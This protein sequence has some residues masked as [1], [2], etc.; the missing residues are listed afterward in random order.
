MV[1]MLAGE[2]AFPHVGKVVFGPGTAVTR[3]ASELGAVGAKAALIVTGRT[4]ANKTDLVDRIKTALGGACVG[5]FSDTFAHTP[6]ET[7]LHGAIVARESGADSLVALGGSTA[8]DTAKG[9]AL[10]LAEGPA[11]AEHEVRFEPPDRWIVPPLLNSKAPIIA[12]PTTLSGGEFTHAFATKDTSSRTKKFYMD[13]KLAPRVIILDPE[14]TAAT[15]RELWAASCIKILCDCV[16]MVCS[17]RRQPYSDALC[18]AAARMIFQDLPVSA[19]EPLDY[20][21]RGRL[22]HTSVMVMSIFM[23]IGVGLAAGLRHEL[24]GMLDTPHGVL[25]SIAIPHVMEFNRPWVPERL[26][27]IAHAAGAEGV[28]LTHDDAAK[29]AVAAVASLSRWMGLPTTLREIGVQREDF[30]SI[31]E[32]IAGDPSARTN[33]RPFGKKDVLDLLAKAY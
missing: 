18:L 3:T 7:V 31:A 13:A 1:E 17:P 23:S 32:H 22:Q 21:A 11:L 10:V 29:E 12:I 15:G 28:D 20:A 25:S 27:L 6:S 9:I 5:V 2:L 33:P 30:E 16:E 26:A 8:S 24:G 14:M 4:L 19:G